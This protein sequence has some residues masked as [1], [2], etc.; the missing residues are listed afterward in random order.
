MLRVTP[1]AVSLHFCTFSSYESF[2]TLIVPLL[3]LCL[4]DLSAKKL[5]V[6]LSIWCSCLVSTDDLPILAQLQYS[7]LRE[8]VPML[9]CATAWNE[10]CTEVHLFSRTGD[11]EGSSALLFFFL[12]LIHRQQHPA[13]STCILIIIL[14]TPLFPFISNSFAI[15][16]TQV[17]PNNRVVSSRTAGSRQIVER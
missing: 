2:Q 17:N 8:T 15:S 13:G 3:G 11:S 10:Q 7:V 1:H 12:S 5:I 6:Y 9:F 16:L 14:H 4:F